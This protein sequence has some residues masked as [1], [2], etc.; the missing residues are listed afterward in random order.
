MRI[1][2]RGERILATL[3]PEL[4]AAVRSN[5]ERARPF[6]DD[7]CYRLAVLLGMRPPD[8]PHGTGA[9]STASQHG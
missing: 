6:T 4:A 3:S 7:E 8:A 1:T 2:E 9:G 5:V